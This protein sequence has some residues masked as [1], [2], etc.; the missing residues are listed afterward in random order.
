MQWPAKGVLCTLIKNKAPNYIRLNFGIT[1][2]F[3]V[4]LVMPNK[5]SERKSQAK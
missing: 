4:H 3:L 2:L 1:S 5:E